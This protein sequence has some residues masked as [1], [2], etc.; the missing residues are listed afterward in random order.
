VLPQE[1]SPRRVQCK[2]ALESIHICG[3]GCEVTDITGPANA[4]RW[5]RCARQTEEFAMHWF[6]ILLRYWRRWND[7]I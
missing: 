7:V 3:E 4:G 5:S 6:H 1:G 2:P